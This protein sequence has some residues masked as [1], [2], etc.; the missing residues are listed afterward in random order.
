MKVDGDKCARQ[1][2]CVVTGDEGTATSEAAGLKEKT[3]IRIVSQPQNQE[4]KMGDAVSFTVK[5]EGTNLKYQWQYKYANSGWK[6]TQMS[7][8]NTDTLTMKVDGDKCARQYRCV[9]TGDEGTATSEAASLGIRQEEIIPTVSISYEGSVS[10]Q[11]EYYVVDG[12]SF[13]LHS[14]KE[15]AKDF[16]WQKSSDGVNFEDDGCPGDSMTFTNDFASLEGSYTQYWRMIVT[17]ETGNQAISNVIKVLFLSDSELPIKPGQDST[18]KG[19]ASTN[20]SASAVTEEKT[21]ENLDNKNEVQPEAGMN[22]DS[23]EK[24]EESA[25]NAEGQEKTAEESATDESAAEEI[26]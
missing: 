6:N 22:G 17:S 23:E 13:T 15:N 18:V 11:N 26:G 2:R 4:G 14:V 7:G 12:G 25:G 9:V 5:A 8:Y 16:K 19:M 1:Y 20:E 24:Q 10:D 3:S 21:E